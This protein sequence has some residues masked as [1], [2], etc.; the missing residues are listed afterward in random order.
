MQLPCGSRGQLARPMWSEGL[1]VGVRVGSS[2]MPKCVISTTRGGA[3]A[4]RAAKMKGNRRRSRRRGRSERYEVPLGTTPFSFNLDGSYLAIS[5]SR[6][7]PDATTSP[8]PATGR[9]I[10][11][12]PTK[13]SPSSPT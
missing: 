1:R 10:S 11:L 3:P 6:M 9:C 8:V 7:P 13:G 4:P 5:T 2:G 12:I